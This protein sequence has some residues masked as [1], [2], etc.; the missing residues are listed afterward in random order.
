MT[1]YS[2][3]LLRQ[4]IRAPDEYADHRSLHPEIAVLPN[5]RGSAT[6]RSVRKSNS[7]PTFRDS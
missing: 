4:S 6:T 5:E 7:G 1:S 2:Y 3:Q